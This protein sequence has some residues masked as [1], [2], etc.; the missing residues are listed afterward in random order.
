MLITYWCRDGKKFYYRKISKSLNFKQSNVSQTT[1]DPRK[2]WSPKV[3]EHVDQ[4]QQHQSSNYVVGSGLIAHSRRNF[5]VWRDAIFLGKFFWYDVMPFSLVG[6]YYIHT[7]MHIDNCMHI[8]RE[9]NK[10]QLYD[11]IFAYGGIELHILSANLMINIIHLI[12]P[13]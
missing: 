3:F 10:C 11:K 7:Y 6:T 2:F 12:Y 4:R 8:C 5:L 1:W 13:F 9:R